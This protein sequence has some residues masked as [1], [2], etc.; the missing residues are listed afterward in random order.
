M[1]VGVQNLPDIEEVNMF[2]DDGTIVQFRKPLSKE[3][4]YF[5]LFSPI[6]GA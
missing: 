6:L 4:N 1:S 3:N 5:Y 2:K